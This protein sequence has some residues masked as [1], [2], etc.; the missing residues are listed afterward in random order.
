MK[1][2]AQVLNTAISEFTQE[3]AKRLHLTNE[4]RL[5]ALS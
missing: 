1:F 4:T 2:E 3:T 5:R